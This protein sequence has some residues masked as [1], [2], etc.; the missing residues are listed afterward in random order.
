VQ[1][2]CQGAWGVVNHDALLREE[3]VEEDEEAG[4]GGTGG[5]FCATVRKMTTSGPDGSNQLCSCT[6]QKMQWSPMLP[7]TVPMQQYD[8]FKAVR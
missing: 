8:V 1:I 6:Q 4:G 2:P 3:E 5:N 7:R